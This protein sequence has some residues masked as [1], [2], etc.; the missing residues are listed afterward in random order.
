MEKVMV[1][2]IENIAK[3]ACS[4]CGVALYD[5]DLKHVSKGQLVLVFITKMGGVTIGDC[6][7]VSRIISEV[8]EEEDFIEERYFLEVSSP[9]LERE[10]K[11]KK[12]YVTAIGELAKITYHLEDK[13]VSIIAM[14]E[15][16]LPDHLLVKLQ[17][18]EMEIP[19]SSI[20]KAKTYFDYKKDKRGEQ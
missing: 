7:K 14:I 19:F 20:K 17:D 16:I 1:E 5:L 15:E 4:Q 11:L 10:L 8:L 13:N 9:G 12:H 18:E 3:D 6:R 2:R